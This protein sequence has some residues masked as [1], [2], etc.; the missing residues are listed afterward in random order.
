MR[1]IFDRQDFVDF[2]DRNS[3]RTYSDMEFRHCRFES[4]GISITRTPKKRSII[5]NMAFHGCETRGCSIKPAIIEDVLVSSLKTHNLLQI[6]GA[7]FKHVK[8]EGNLGDIMISPLIT[9]TLASSKE[10]LAF[11]KINNNYYQTVDWAL[12]ISE[13]RFIDCELQRVP[14]RLVRRDPETQVVITREK[15]LSGEWKKLDLSKTYWATSI[16]FFLD[17]GDQDVVLV[18]PKQYS[19]YPDLLDGLKMLRDAGVAEPD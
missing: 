6:W 9:P 5:R 10:Q 12:D 1:K 17:R 19:K 11:D 7:V 4:C 8:L 13:A 16:K 18:A 15:A 14:A 3:G 2:V